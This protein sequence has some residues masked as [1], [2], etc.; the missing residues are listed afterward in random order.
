M[1]VSEQH[2]PVS[3]E[4]VNSPAFESTGALQALK[5]MISRIMMESE[6]LLPLAEQKGF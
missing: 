5:P 6:N 3:I 4:W 1:R 2:V